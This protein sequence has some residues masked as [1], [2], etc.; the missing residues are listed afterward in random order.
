MKARFWIRSLKNVVNGSVNQLVY[1]IY[2]VP[3]IIVGTLHA[4]TN[5]IIAHYEEGDVISIS[6]RGKQRHREV[7]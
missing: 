5:L 3:G 4:L 1:G 7:S 6:Q 2:T